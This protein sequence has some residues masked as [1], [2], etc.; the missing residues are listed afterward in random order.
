[1]SWGFAFLGL[2]WV[3]LA[4]VVL[5]TAAWCSWTAT[6]LDRMH[7]RYEAARAA[8]RAD[9]LQ[10]S[11]VAVELAAGGLSDPASALVLLDAAHAARESEGA[12]EVAEAAWMQESDL[13]RAL[14]AVELPGPELEPLVGEL[15]TAARRA[16]MARRICNDLVATTLAL[17]KRRRVRWFRLAG[18]A[19]PPA[20][21]DFDDRVP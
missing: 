8:L 13:T 4:L 20:M 10:R 12:E 21:V 16:S 2:A 15:R 7:L 11:A 3:L 9:L 19:Q 5:A 14:H 6:R 18:R 1:M 17:R